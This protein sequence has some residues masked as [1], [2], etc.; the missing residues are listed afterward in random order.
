MIALID[1]NIVLDALQE[2]KP[3]DVSA[4]EILLS[5]QNGDFNCLFTAN[6]VADIFYLY[7]K[8][9]NAKS[10]KVVMKFLL[11]SFGVI[12]VTHED[13]VNALSVPIDDFEDALV[14][15]CAQKGNVN[16]IVTRDEE[17]LNSK[18]SPQAVSPTK[19][20]ELVQK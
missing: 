1:T 14:Y 17:M 19:F 9:R 13:C 6:S 18:L 20:L 8:A 16:Y 15:V 5:S 12:S 3:F 7:S 11:K 2:R 4:K 10:A